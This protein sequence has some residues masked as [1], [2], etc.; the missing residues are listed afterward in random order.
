MERAFRRY[1]TNI[2]ARAS[3]QETI[4]FPRRRRVPLYLR[5]LP[6]N[7]S[8][9]LPR[10]PMKIRLALCLCAFLAAPLQA[11]KGSAVV[12]GLGAG[13]LVEPSASSEV[14][15]PVA[16]G[17]RVKLL[18]REGEWYAVRV[19]NRV[20]WMHSSALQ[21][22]GIGG[23]SASSQGVGNSQRTQQIISPLTEPPSASRSTRAFIRGPRGGC[24]YIGGS[25]RK[26]YV[27]RSLCG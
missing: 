6:L 22:S 7:P 13:L 12:T 23:A 4:G 24:Y 10:V 9:E 2:A 5:V 14:S 19:L 15:Q 8:A 21:A 16:V 1:G 17:T 26:V 11:Q 20:G 18:D 27:D 25:G 3:E